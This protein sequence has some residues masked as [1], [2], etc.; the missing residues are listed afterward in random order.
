MCCFYLWVIGL[1]IKVYKYYIIVKYYIIFFYVCFF[2]KVENFVISYLII[3]YFVG[4]FFIFLV[5][6]DVGNNNFVVNYKFYIMG[7]YLIIIF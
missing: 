3:D 2:G 5:G 4:F 1:G 6:D 7:K